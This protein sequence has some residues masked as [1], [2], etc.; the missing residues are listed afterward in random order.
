MLTL[1]LV[2]APV[3]LAQAAAPPAERPIAPLSRGRSAQCAVVG[4][5][6]V[7]AATPSKGRTVERALGPGPRFSVARTL[8][9]RLAALPRGGARPDAVLELRLYTPG[10]YLYQALRA[11]PPAAG[12]RAAGKPG[13]WTAV[14][15]LA[16]T[17]IVNSSLYGQWR[18]EPHLDGSPRP[19][20]PAQRFW[21]AP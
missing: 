7:P 18:V 1:G 5:A 12:D 15:P 14:L 17:A 9:L 19:C 21:I 13:T 3:L 20:G 4:L 6:A 10:G 16:G 2:L 11:Q 8:D